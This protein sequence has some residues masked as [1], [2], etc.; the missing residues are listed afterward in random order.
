MEREEVKRTIEQEKVKY[1]K[2]IKANNIK[3]E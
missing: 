3:D 1:N 2:L